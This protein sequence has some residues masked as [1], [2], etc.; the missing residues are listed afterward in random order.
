MVTIEQAIEDL[1]KVD[2]D[3]ED[4]CTTR[5]EVIILLEAL[6]DLRNSKERIIERLANEL[7]LADKEKERCVKENVLQFDS[8]KGY[9]SGMYMAIEI[10]KAELNW[11][12]SEWHDESIKPQVHK[13]VVVKDSDGKEYTDHQWI[14][15]AWYDYCRGMDGSCDGW[16]TD[17]DVISW[18]YQEE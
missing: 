11:H 10:V 8:V 7:T 3:R 17:V 2:F 9:S 5:G 18:R 15:H 4:I 16:R 1:K 6:K 12:T 13:W 14:G